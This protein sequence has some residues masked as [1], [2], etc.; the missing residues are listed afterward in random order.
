M[1]NIIG[2]S[3]IKV[4]ESSSSLSAS[5]RSDRSF[6]RPP[7]CPIAC[8]PG[9]LP[10]FF[11][12]CLFLLLT[13][14]TDRLLACLIACIAL[15]FRGQGLGRMMYTMVNPWFYRKCFAHCI[16]CHPGFYRHRFVN[17]CHYRNHY[18]S[19]HCLSRQGHSSTLTTIAMRGRHFEVRVILLG[20]VLLLP[21]VYCSN[22]QR[23]KFSKSKHKLPA[24]QG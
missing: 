12:V 23:A 2:L 1:A 24:C 19:S 16:R 5:L 3:K 14:C 17:H 9:W 13:T 8:L 10:A 21:I 20:R 4:R 6:L 18:A 11:L 7:F 15:I 22:H